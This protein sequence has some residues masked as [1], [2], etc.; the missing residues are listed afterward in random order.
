MS[1]FLISFEDAIAIIKRLKIKRHNKTFKWSYDLIETEMKQ[2]SREL[3]KLY[4]EAFRV[5]GYHRDMFPKMYRNY[6]EDTLICVLKVYREL[7]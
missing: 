3:P 6:H 4:P 1:V 5:E 7:A 2:Y